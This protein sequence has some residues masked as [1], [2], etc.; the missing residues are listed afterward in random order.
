MGFRRGFGFGRSRG[1]LALGPEIV[2]DPGF[3]NAPSWGVSGGWAISGSAA[4]GT[5]ANGFVFQSNGGVVAGRTYRVS[6]V[7]A[8]RTAGSVRAY[9]GTGATYTPAQS[10]PGTYTFDLVAGSS[11][12]LGLNSPDGF[13]GTVTSIS[14]K[15]AG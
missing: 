13:S 5:A 4:T 12:E 1:V 10:A 8:T 15:Q 9:I 2:V 6:F 14:V 11:G 3:D 7:V